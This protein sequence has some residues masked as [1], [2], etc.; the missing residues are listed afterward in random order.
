V[1]FDRTPLRANVYEIGYEI[2]PAYRRQGYAVE[3]T[4]RI[5]RWLLEE[6]DAARVIA[7]C[8]MRNVASVRTLRRLGFHL[9]GSS[10]RGNAFWW[11]YPDTKSAA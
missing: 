5:I 3:A 8:S 10:A 1:R 11:V 9:D 7:G 6:A 2:A 4:A